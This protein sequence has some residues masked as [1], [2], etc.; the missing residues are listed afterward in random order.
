LED[1][2]KEK[3]SEKEKASNLGPSK[4]VT[5]RKKEGTNPVSI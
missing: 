3:R 4:N 1:E 5:K 2:V